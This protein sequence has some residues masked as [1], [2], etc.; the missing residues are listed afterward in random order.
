MHLRSSNRSPPFL[1]CVSTHLFAARLRRA[2]AHRRFG[3]RNKREVWRVKLTLAKIPKVAR[4]LLMLEDKDP[5][6]LFEGN[7]LLRRLV[8]S[9][10]LEEEKMKLDY[11]LALRVD[12]FLERRLRPKCSSSY[13]PTTAGNC[14]GGGDEDQRAERRPEDLAAHPFLPSRRIG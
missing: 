11:V 6:C 1:N 5:K 13:S 3:L 8:L 12:D 10:V 4:E 14:G 9:G 7:V 2:E